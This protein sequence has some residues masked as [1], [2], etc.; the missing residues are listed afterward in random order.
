LGGSANCLSVTDSYHA[1]GDDHVDIGGPTP[2]IRASDAYNPN[3]VLGLGQTT[4][5]VSGG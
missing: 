1:R 5:S 3:L 4:I 2:N